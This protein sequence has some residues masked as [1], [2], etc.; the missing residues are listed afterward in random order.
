MDEDGKKAYIV[1]VTDPS[2]LVEVRPRT[3]DPVDV[4]L[5]IACGSATSIRTFFAFIFCDP[6]ESQPM[7]TWR[8]SVQSLKRVDVSCIQGQTVYHS[9]VVRLVN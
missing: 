3:S 4:L 8:I 5:K 1:R 7:Q 2:V 9:I 6:F